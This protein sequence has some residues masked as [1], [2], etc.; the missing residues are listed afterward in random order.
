MRIE[1]EK[2]PDFFLLFYQKL[3]IKQNIDHSKIAFYLKYKS[4]VFSL[5]YVL[6]FIFFCDFVM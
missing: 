4:N 6:R 2:A 3:M 1:Q 5:I